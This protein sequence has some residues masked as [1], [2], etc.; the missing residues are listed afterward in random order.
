LGVFATFCSRAFRCAVKLL[1][2]DLSNFF[3]ETLR[4]MSYHLSTA[5]IVSHKFCICCALIF[6]KF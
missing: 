1:E 2:Y 6:I 5:F 4:A 3:M